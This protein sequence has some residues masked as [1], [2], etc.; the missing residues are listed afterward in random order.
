[1]ISKLPPDKRKES[2]ENQKKIKVRHNAKDLENAKILSDH[3]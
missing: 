3:Y 1:M 2:E